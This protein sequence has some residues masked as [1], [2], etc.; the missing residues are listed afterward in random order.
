MSVP[1]FVQSNGDSGSAS[2]FTLSMAGNITA[3]NQVLVFIRY[4]AAMTLTAI[5]LPGSEV[6]TLISGPFTEVGANKA[7]LYRTLSATGGGTDL[8]LTFDVSGVCQMSMIEYTGGPNVIDFAGFVN[9]GA[10]TSQSAPSCTA[11]AA[12]QMTIS[13]C[14]INSAVSMAPGN[15]ETERVDQGRLQI[16]EKLTSG[17]GAVHNVVTLGSSIGATMAQIIL[18]GSTATPPQLMLVGVGS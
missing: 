6:P 17:S 11:T 4:A 18:G 10:S 8:N 1:T 13:F 16:E 2:S 14:D 15:G 9:N 3:G 7:A 12:N 5:T